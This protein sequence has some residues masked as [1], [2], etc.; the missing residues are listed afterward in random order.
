MTCSSITALR[1]Q[2]APYYQYRAVCGLVFTVL[3]YVLPLRPSGPRKACRRC[4]K[5]PAGHI[6]MESPSGKGISPTLQ[7]TRAVYNCHSSTSYSTPT[8]CS[9]GFLPWGLSDACLK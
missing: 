9:R 6:E 2:I 3:L 1:Q 4:E 5:N 7:Y 8:L